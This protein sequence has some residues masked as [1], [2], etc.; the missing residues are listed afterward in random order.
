MSIHSRRDA[1]GRRRYDVR[2]RD[3]QGRQRRKTFD[4]RHQAQDF[5]A[6]QQINGAK[7]D[8]REGSGVTIPLRQYAKSWFES[9]AALR[10]RTRDTYEGLLRLHILPYLGDRRLDQITISLVRAWQGELIH[11]K[12]QNLGAKTY[13]LLS[14]IL[15]T[16]VEDGLISKNPCTIR[17]AGIERSSERPIA[18]LQQVFLLAD[19]IDPRYR[20]AVLL[21]CF[22]GLRK[23]EILALKPDRFDLIERTVT[24]R[25]QRQERANGTFWIGDPKTSAGTRVVSLPHFMMEEV[26]MHIKKYVGNAS[27]DLLFR[28]LQGGPLRHAV[29]HR[30]WTKARAGLGLEHLHFHD[31]RHTGNTLAASTGASTRE[32]MVRMG[33]SSAEAALKYQ[34]ASRERDRVIASKLDAMVARTEHRTPP[35]GHSSGPLVG[36]TTPDSE[37]QRQVA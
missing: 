20:L 34:H 9:R 33:H 5:A 14:A 22:A 24:I 16:A 13:R 19:A 11:G 12:S 23:G 28:G 32:L 30:A 10:P 36:P 1:K 8:S 6:I 18:T 27:S 29:L 4:T 26:E 15:N 31:L 37:E 7:R 17:G 21:A 35:A 2:F 3:L 25:E